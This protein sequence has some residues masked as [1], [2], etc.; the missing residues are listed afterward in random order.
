MRDRLAH[1]VERPRKPQRKTA[2]QSVVDARRDDEVHAVGLRPGVGLVGRASR[3]VVELQGQR[4]PFKRM[5]GHVSRQPE[6]LDVEVRGDRVAQNEG[7]V[8][9]NLQ[10]RVP[11]ASVLLAVV[12]DD[13]PRADDLRKAPLSRNADSEMPGLRRFVHIVPVAP[14]QLVVRMEFEH[15]VQRRK[16]QGGRIVTPGVEVAALLH[17]PVDRQLHLL[18]PPQGHTAPEHVK[19]TQ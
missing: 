4:Q 15:V 18:L 2:A 12:V 7:V 19:Q 11:T 17:L 1:Q 10:R 16:P 14:F 8:V 9:G 6:P 3:V 5:V 13:A